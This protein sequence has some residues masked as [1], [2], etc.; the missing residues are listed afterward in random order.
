MPSSIREQDLLYTEPAQNILI[1][2]PSYGTI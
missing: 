1:P 2:Q